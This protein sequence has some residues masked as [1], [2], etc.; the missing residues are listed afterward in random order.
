MAY[1]FV[2]RHDWCTV[3]AHVNQPVFMQTETFGR[4]WTRPAEISFFYS[5]TSEN[6][7]VY[8]CCIIRS[9]NKFYN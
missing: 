3:T 4:E 9:Y 6:I 5:K 8:T 2:I 1:S 7:V